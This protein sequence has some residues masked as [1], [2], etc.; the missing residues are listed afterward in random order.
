MKFKDSITDW[1][2]PALLLTPHI[3]L[4]IAIFTFTVKTKDIGAFFSIL[5]DLSG[6]LF[7][8]I[9]TIIAILAFSHWK[10]QLKAT[11]DRE[12]K[13]ALKDDMYSLEYN[14]SKILEL[15]HS[16]EN[17]SSAVIQSNES[18]PPEMIPPP[19]PSIKGDIEESFIQLSS[20]DTYHKANF[21]SASEDVVKNLKEMIT[22][23]CRF[24]TDVNDTHKLIFDLLDQKEC[25][26][27]TDKE[28][29]DEMEKNNFDDI[30]HN[31]LTASRLIMDFSRNNPL[32]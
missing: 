17:Y 31:Y 11:W 7:G 18:T 14:L 12:T 8:L 27:I 30:F 6:I 16:I 22:S 5:T 15:W 23:A 2:M 13:I 29:R 21:L 4:L 9:M 19:P 32:D 10:R 28:F 24:S 1:V 3:I 20:F 26:F 25:G